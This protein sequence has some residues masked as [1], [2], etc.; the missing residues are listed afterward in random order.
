MGEIKL[1]KKREDELIKWRVVKPT[2]KIEAEP[3]DIDI[4]SDDASD[5]SSV[6]IDNDPDRSLCLDWVRNV[7]GA[8]GTNRESVQTCEVIDL[9]SGTEDRFNDG[10]Y[11]TDECYQRLLHSWNSEHSPAEIQDVDE[12]PP[13]SIVLQEICVDGI[14][15]KPGQCLELIDETFI[16]VEVIF[17]NVPGDIQFGGRRLIKA[18]NHMGTYVPKWHNELVWISNETAPIRLNLVKRFV[19]I[20]FTNYC[21]I[22][23]DTRKKKKPLD[24]F[25]RLKEYSASGPKE[26]ASI[27]Y[28]SFEEADEGFKHRP[29]SLRHAWRGDTRPFGEG[30]VSSIA[31]DD[32]VVDLTDEGPITEQK[33]HRQYTFGDSFCGAGGVSCGARSAGLRPR[34]AFDHSAYAVATY[35]LNY[36]TAECEGSDVFNFL[37]NDYGFLKIDISHGSPPCQTWSPAKTIESVND[38]A[39]SA[40]IFSCSNIIRQARPRVHTMEETSGLSERHKD[41]LYRVIQDFVEIGYSVRWAMLDCVKYG[42]PQFRK[43]LVIIASGP[44][45]TLPPLPKPTHGLPGSGLQAYVTISQVISRIPLGVPDHDVEK[46]L[47]RGFSRAPFNPNQQ[48][49]TITCGGGERNYHPS[50]RRGFTNREFACLQTFPMGYR[51]GQREVRK[52]IGNAVPPVLAEAFY[53]AI[54]D[55]LHETDERELSEEQQGQGS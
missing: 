24:I 14:V 33:K 27:E 6:T 50:G 53:R 16:R 3:I 42:V 37:T 34:W 9:T 10:D 30:E 38:D 8:A 20:N 44:G 15:Y 49:R 35:R 32:T 17:Q 31:L 4:D 36:D 29:A 13:Q 19:N 7:P 47:G 43:R 40:C 18:R 22:D 54:K 5:T 41:T 1:T 21:H 45:E 11:L 48:A 39:N 55:S 12:R 52:Q 25:C 51:F 28:I 23:Q 26:A 2:K 46:A